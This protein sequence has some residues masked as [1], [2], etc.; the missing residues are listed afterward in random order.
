MRHPLFVTD[1]LT[2]QSVTFI[3]P[4]EEHPGEEK[5]ASKVVIIGVKMRERRDNLIERNM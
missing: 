3:C 4:R 1:W 5:Q 2:S